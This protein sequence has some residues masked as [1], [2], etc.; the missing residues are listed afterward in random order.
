MKFKKVLLTSIT[1]AFFSIVPLPKIDVSLCLASI[2][3]LKL[4]SIVTIKAIEKKKLKEQTSFKTEVTVLVPT[5]NEEVGIENTINSILN[6]IDIVPPKIIIIDDGSTDKTFEIVNQKFGNN[7]RIQIISKPNSGKSNSLNVGLKNVKTKLYISIDGDSI[8]LPNTISNLIK[9][10]EDP[11]IN[12][13]A[14]NVQIGNEFFLSDHKT[15]FNWLTT[16]Q[17][18]EYIT[19]KNFDK[20]VMSNFGVY[21]CIPGAIGCYRTNDVRIIG[22]YNTDC[23]GEDTLLTY[24]LLKM[25]KVKYEPNAV[26]YTEAPENSTE[27]IKQR[28]RWTFGMFEVLKLNMNLIINPINHPVSYYIAPSLLLSIIGSCGILA[29]LVYLVLEFLVNKTS[30]INFILGISVNPISGL[31]F[32]LFIINHLL[33]FCDSK[34]SHSKIL[35]LFI[36]IKIVIMSTIYSISF[37]KA[38]TAF[39]T[40]QKPKW[41]ILKRTGNIRFIN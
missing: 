5:H 40:G 32:L 39:S 12:G 26:C 33:P 37:A 1:T 35:L 23:M 13:V 11:T 17:R 28:F 19:G 8:F 36:P 25:G 9:H 29:N 15:S 21:D 10:F 20:T 38:L 4:A 7:S 16:S 18:L 2:E 14:G 31:L 27:L 41:G 6:S 30:M 3:G 24:E 22:G 34:T